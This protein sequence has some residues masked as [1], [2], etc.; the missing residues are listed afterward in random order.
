M[1]VSGSSETLVPIYYTTD[2]ESGKTVIKPLFVLRVEMSIPNCSCGWNVCL[3]VLIA[4]H[5]RC[6]CLASQSSLGTWPR[7]RSATRWTD[8]DDL[9]CSIPRFSSVAMVTET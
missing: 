3:V 2:V 1:A 4:R 6:V 8:D 5:A 7:P 9:R